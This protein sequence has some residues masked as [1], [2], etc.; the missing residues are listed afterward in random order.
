MSAEPVSPDAGEVLRLWLRSE[1]A[2]T[3]VVGTRIGLTLTGD[4]PSIRYH[5]VSGGDAPGAG[6]VWVTYG[7]ECWGATN[8]PDDGSTL[9]LAR[10]IKSIAPNLCGTIGG[11]QVAGASAGYPYRQDD[12]TANRVRH[13]VE[14]TFAVHP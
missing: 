5:L 2:V 13:I 14:V 12:T 3:A 9:G 10:T 7:V 8:Q 1:S 11:A 4:Q 6:S